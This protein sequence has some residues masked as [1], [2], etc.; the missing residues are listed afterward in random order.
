MIYQCTGRSFWNG[1]AT[2]LRFLLT[3]LLLGIAATLVASIVGA[4][5]TRSLNLQQVM[6]DYGW[7]LLQCL[8][9]VAGLK[10]LFEASFLRHR[11]DKQNTPSK[12]SALLLTGVLA[13]ATGYRFAI[14]MIGGVLLP[15]LLIAVAAS[16]SDDP[17]DVVLS[18]ALTIIF[19]AC[20]V[21]ELLERYLFFT[22]VVAPRMPGRH[23]T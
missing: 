1:S 17:R 20:L 21:G 2:S 15:V 22:A 7:R 19:A 14:G 8:A 5:L 4:G 6:T 23:V 16:G 3:T 18:V 10:L 13:R 11:R 12:R 9:A